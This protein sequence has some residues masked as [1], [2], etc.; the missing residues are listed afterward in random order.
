MKVDEIRTLFAY[1]RWATGR[2]LEA[3]RSLSPADFAQNLRTSHD[4]VRG[5]LVHTMWAEWI[6]LQRWR[7]TS[8]RQVFAEDQ[9]PDAAA[10][11][12][13]WAEVERDRQA[14]LADLTED[15][16][17]GRIPYEN[18]RG[19]RFEYALGH[20]MQHVVNHSSYHRGQIVTLLRQLGWTP[21]TTDFLVFFDEG[22]R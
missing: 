3:C 1:S 17:V 7:G 4:S 16:L 9:F 10:L 14:L 5:T 22:G 13:R 6:W 20:M 12:V 11:E 2:M 19:Q 15:R 18:L 21:P 8:P